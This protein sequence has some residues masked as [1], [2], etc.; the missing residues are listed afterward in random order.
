MRLKKRRGGRSLARS[1][2]NPQMIAVKNMV[3]EI[4]VSTSFSQMLHR[5][6]LCPSLLACSPQ[7]LKIAAEQL[8]YTCKTYHIAMLKCKHDILSVLFHKCKVLYNAGE[9]SQSP[10]MTVLQSAV[11][12]TIMFP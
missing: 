6:V 12:S 10:A 4:K 2:L 1:N 7:I 5:K 9:P 8:S 11:N 3:I